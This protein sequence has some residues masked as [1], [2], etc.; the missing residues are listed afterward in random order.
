M[1]SN[2]D[3]FYI[4]IEALDAIYDFVVEKVFEL[5]LFS[6]PKYYCMFIDFKI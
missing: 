1:N 3:K 2:K 5:K 4:K 6:V